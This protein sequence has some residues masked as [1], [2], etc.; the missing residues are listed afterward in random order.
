MFTIGEKIK[1]ING[2]FSQLSAH[3]KQDL[4][5]EHLRFPEEGKI[6]TVRSIVPIPAKQSTGLL[7]EEI[8]NPRVYPHNG[9]VVEINFDEKRF[10][11]LSPA[12]VAEEVEELEYV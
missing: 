6:Y 10:R 8:K 11:K 2:D 1:C 5:F 9:L 3:T 4:W 12:E 7:L